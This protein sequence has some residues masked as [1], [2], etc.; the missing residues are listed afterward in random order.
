MSWWSAFRLSEPRCHTGV[1]NN[2]TSQWVVVI[3]NRINALIKF[4]TNMVKWQ[5]IPKFNNLCVRKVSSF[6]F[7]SLCSLLQ[8]SV[9]F[10]YFICIFCV[11]MMFFCLSNLAQEIGLWL[12]KLISWRMLW[13]QPLCCA[14]SSNYIMSLSN[15][16]DLLRRVLSQILI[17]GSHLLI[18]HHVVRHFASCKIQQHFFL[19]TA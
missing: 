12:A 11:I 17:Y 3:W 10:F 1:I 5:I 8:F 13:V 16:T 7:P 2:Y 9:N 15:A 19:F 4:T 14:T 6:P 18:S